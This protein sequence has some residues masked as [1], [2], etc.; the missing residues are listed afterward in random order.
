MHAWVHKCCVGEVSEGALQAAEHLV[1]V[2]VRQIQPPTTDQYI[3]II[4]IIIIN[5]PM[6]KKTNK[7]I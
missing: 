2:A 4:N 6:I 3:I 5:M 7:Y 1:A